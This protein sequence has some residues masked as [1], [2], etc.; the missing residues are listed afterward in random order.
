M[1]FAGFQ[2]AQEGGLADAGLTEH[3]EHGT[4][5]GASLLHERGK[6]RTFGLAAV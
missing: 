6:A 3:D 5:P 4:G 1:L 2:V